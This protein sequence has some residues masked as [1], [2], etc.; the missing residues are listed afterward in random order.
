MSASLALQGAIVAALKADAA[1]A[2]IV[3]GRIFDIIPP[4]AQMPYISLGEDQVL[5]DGGDCFDA[6]DIRSAIHLWSRKVG[7]PEV[8]RL[9]A[10]VD[11]AL[12]D[13]LA[14][15]GHFIIECGVTDTRFLRDPDGLTSHAVLSLQTLIETAE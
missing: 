10:A 12:G 2:A 13:E 1:V 11:A 14:V 7:M 15:P 3:A 9:A 4:G 6:Y 5:P 8:K